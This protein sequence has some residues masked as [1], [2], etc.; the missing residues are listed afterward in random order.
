LVYSSTIRFIMGT[1]SG[2]TGQ[3]AHPLIVGQQAD[4]YFP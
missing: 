3:A 1:W 4:E 2:T